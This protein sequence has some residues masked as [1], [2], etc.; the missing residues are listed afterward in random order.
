MPRL[1]DEELHCM[2]IPSMVL[3]NSLSCEDWSCIRLRSKHKLRYP[4]VCKIQ[5]LPLDS[6]QPKNQGQTRRLGCLSL[7]NPSCSLRH[8]RE[9]E[10]S[11][12]CSDDA[13]T[14]SVNNGGATTTGIGG[15]PS[16]LIKLMPMIAVRMTLPSIIRPKTTRSEA[17]R[18]EG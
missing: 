1:N 6:D 8:Q 9:E 16:E 4:H 14:A 5:R 11:V 15:W 17:Y 18:L 13:R 10:V 3:Q 7:F 12:Q 2:S